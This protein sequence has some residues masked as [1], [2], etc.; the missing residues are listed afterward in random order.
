[1]IWSKYTRRDVCGIT[2]E[3]VRALS[4]HYG[5]FEADIEKSLSSDASA[6]SVTVYFVCSYCTSGTLK[7]VLK[8]IHQVT[9]YSDIV[10]CLTT[11]IQIYF[12]FQSYDGSV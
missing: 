8:L 9:C 12:T 10:K 11:C 2:S 7:N 3:N 1:M 5:W 4:L 6:R